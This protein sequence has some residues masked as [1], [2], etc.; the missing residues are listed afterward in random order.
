MP[1]KVKPLGASNAVGDDQ[2]PGH[3]HSHINE[4]IELIAKHE[5]EFLAQR[6]Q[7]ERVADRMAS[8]IGSLT[9]VVAHIIIFGVWSL[10]N[11]L[12]YPELTHFD[13][14]P[15]PFLD[16]IFAFEAILVASFILMRQSRMSRRAEERDQLM[17]QILLLSEREITAVLGVERQ[18][19]QRM[20]LHRVAQDQEISEL[21]EHTSF[22]DVAQV[23]KEN[24]P[25]E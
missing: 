10:W 19:A 16:T 15:F 25:S 3:L 8:L 1:D 7:S 14:F 2:E 17:L 5:Q 11:L 13:P 18:I 24:F 4:H 9:Y 6:T 20:G 12:P 22:E 23:I 21:S